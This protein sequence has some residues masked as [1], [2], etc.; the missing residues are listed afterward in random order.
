MIKHVE[1]T[2]N[3]LRD[4]FRLLEIQ[5][6]WG[7]WVDQVWNLRSGNFTIETNSFELVLK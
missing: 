5:G 3:M 2:R 7:Y 6:N 1:R 4:A